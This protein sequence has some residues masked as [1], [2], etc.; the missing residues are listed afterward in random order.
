MAAIRLTR[1]LFFTGA[2]FI[3]K[4][5]I[6]K[7]AAGAPTLSVNNIV[8]SYAVPSLTPFLP[9]QNK[10]WMVT[11]KRIISTCHQLQVPWEYAQRITA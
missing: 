9:V 1:A 7:F 4:P 3:G 8:S 6:A 10:K 5:L 11:T 2:T